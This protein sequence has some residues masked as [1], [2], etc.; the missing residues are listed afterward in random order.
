MKHLAHA[1]TLALTGFWGMGTVAAAETP[2]SPVAHIDDGIEQAAEAVTAALETSLYHLYVSPQ[3][4]DANPGTEASPFRT[5][6]RAANVAK[7]STTIHVAEGAYPGNIDS[8]ASGTASGR[9]IF[10]S[11]KAHPAKVVGTGTE[12][13]WKNNGSFVDIIG[14]D[15]S[16]PGRLGIY[17]AGSNTRII[18]NHVHDLAVSGGCTGNGGAGILNGNY[19][20]S[21]NDVI[22][23]Y[24]HDIGKPGTCNG[25]QGI[26]HSNL[27][28]HIYNNVVYRVSAYG[29]HLWHAA[30]NVTIANNDTFANGSA[31]MG[32]GILI[33]AGDSPGGIVLDYT[34][35]HNNIVY[36][37]PGVGI[38]EYCYDGEDCIGAHNTV[39]NNLVYGNGRGIIMKVGSAT[40][41]VVA[42]PRFR[43]YSQIDLRLRKKSPAIDKGTADG[44]PADDM[45]HVARPRGNGIDIGAYESH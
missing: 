42:N 12:T 38:I 29:I 39:A 22:G 27:R 37:N 2:A 35:V 40:D 34:K 19:S 4:S 6:Q 24:V 32:G 44:A 18:N 41:T 16:G 23:N 9:V 8:S 15:V 14:F 28:G 3:G 30:N 10:L 11:D 21:D 43:D 26:Y 31:T 25:V 5:I 7:A 17:N 1:L 45:R 20:A 36:D 33:G 13:M